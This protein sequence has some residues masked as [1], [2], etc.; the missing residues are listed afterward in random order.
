MQYKKK[1]KRKKKGKRL[2]K[3]NME[4]TKPKHT[5]IEFVRCSSSSS[6]YVVKSKQITI[7]STTWPV[8][9]LS[10]PLLLYSP[11][12]TETRQF[13]S[14]EETQGEEEEER[15]KEEEEQEADEYNNC[16]KTMRI[17]AS[18]AAADCLAA[19]PKLISTHN[20]ESHY[21]PIPMKCAPSGLSAKSDTLQNARASREA[22]HITFRL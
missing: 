8:F 9:S 2:Y 3:S 7:T 5:L 15:G 18:L 12:T 22:Q 21:Q 14:S 16:P 20:C 1:L 4:K 19:R 10:L 6:V 17:V 11:A 13:Y